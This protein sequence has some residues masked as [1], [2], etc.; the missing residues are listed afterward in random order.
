MS[1][2]QNVCKCIYCKNG[3]RKGSMSAFFYYDE[4]TACKIM[5]VVVCRFFCKEQATIC[6]MEWVFFCGSSPYACYE[7]YRQ[8]KA[9]DAKATE[10]PTPIKG[11]EKIFDTY[12]SPWAQWATL[13]ICVQKI[14]KIQPLLSTDFR[15][16]LRYVK[17]RITARAVISKLMFSA[18]NF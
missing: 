10:K 11:R 16:F 2:Y 1:F 4:Q 13:L 18:W 17:F 14:R 5:T 12:S 8:K 15:Q 7:G 3:L 9:A 6:K